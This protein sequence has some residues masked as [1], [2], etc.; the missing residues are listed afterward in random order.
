MSYHEAKLS[1]LS[2]LLSCRVPR[3]TTHLEL[4]SVGRLVLYES[5]D[6]NSVWKIGSVIRILEP[7]IIESC[8]WSNCR[9][10]CYNC[11]FAAWVH[12]IAFH[13]RRRN[14]N[15][16]CHQFRL[17]STMRNLRELAGADLG[18]FAERV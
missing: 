18:T 1:V 14:Q 8:D 17:L 4:L 15:L 11:A 13:V 5:Q 7:T 3:R 9:L 16:P 12:H 10:S 6:R 2:P